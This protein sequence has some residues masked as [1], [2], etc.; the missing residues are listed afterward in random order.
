MRIRFFC[1]VPRVRKR[2]KTAKHQARYRFALNC[3]ATG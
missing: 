3:R 2:L 1:L